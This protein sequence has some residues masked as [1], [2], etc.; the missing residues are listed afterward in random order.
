MG[1]VEAKIDKCLNLWW[2]KA[3]EVGAPVEQRLVSLSNQKRFHAILFLVNAYSIVKLKIIRNK[4]M[5]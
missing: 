5:V 4:F 2:I 3:G 1:M